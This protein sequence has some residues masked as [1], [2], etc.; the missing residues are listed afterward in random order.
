[1]TFNVRTDVF[2]DSHKWDDRRKV[3]VDIIKR[4][5][6]DIVG[7][8]ET[9]PHMLQYLKDKLR[10]FEG[11]GVS[12][13]PYST[14]GESTP[15]FINKKTFSVLS[16]ESFMLSKTPDVPASKS[17]HAA[18]T[19]ICSLVHIAKKGSK[20]PLMVFAN[21]HLDHFSKKA[22]KEGLKLIMERIKNRLGSLPFVIAGDFN[23]TPDSAIFNCLKS[24]TLSCFDH[25]EENQKDSLLTCHGFTHRKNGSP[26]DY[27]FAS[28]NSKIIDTSII[29]DRGYSVIPSDH[30][31]VLSTISL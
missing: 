22:R 19:R 27:I 28:K 31:P 4:Y 26:I 29:R 10:G 1:M 7:L 11:Y 21:T 12:R 25:I 20:T 15:I 16:R 17:W 6:P 8:Q 5:R 23:D 13:N 18:C 24:D 14:F 2:T 30:Y 9:R 3:I